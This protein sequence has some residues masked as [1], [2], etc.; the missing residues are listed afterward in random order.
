M[1]R[2]LGNDVILYSIHVAVCFIPPK[3]KIKTKGKHGA[4]HHHQEFLTVSY[5]FFISKEEILYCLV[6]SSC[7]QELFR[8]GS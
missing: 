3:C 4:V 5:F 2:T 7:T 8:I 6:L 1:N